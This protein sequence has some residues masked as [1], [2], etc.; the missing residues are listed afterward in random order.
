MRP[1]GLRGLLLVL[2]L[3][4]GCDPPSVTVV[5]ECR[6][7]ERPVD[8]F[9]R[10]VDE[11][12]DPGHAGDVIEELLRLGPIEDAPAAADE[13]ELDPGAVGDHGRFPLHVNL[14]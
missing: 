10:R 8:A 13:G 4:A 3:L 5:V 11:A 7:I 2:P 14:L 9:E 6:L 12:Q 1:R